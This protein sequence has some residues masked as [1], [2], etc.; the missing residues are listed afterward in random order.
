MLHAAATLL[1]ILPVMSGFN[2]LATRPASSASAPIA[3]H[4]ASPRLASTAE[5]HPAVAA[6]WPNTCAGGELSQ[7]SAQVSRRFLLRGALW[8]TGMYYGSGTIASASAYTVQKVEPDELE[9]YAEAQKGDGP[10]R[11]LWVGPEDLKGVFKGL[12]PAGNEVIALDLRRPD[13]KDLSAAT[14]YATEHGYQLRFEQGDATRLNFTDG[15]FDVVVSSMFLCQ[16]FN[17]EVVVSEIRR[18]LKPGGR[19]GFYEHVQDIDKVVVDKVFG[20]RSVIQVQGD[21][22]LTNVIAG[23]VR[24]M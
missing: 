20:K 3:C 2:L 17:P 5:T 11:V 15:A 16:D 14:T 4:A 22:F 1:L 19:F 12:F 24:K 21:P 10:L 23:V 7:Q 6:A 9:T 8:A 13:A 18:V